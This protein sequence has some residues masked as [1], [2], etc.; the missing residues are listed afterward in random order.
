M[1]LEI[2]IIKDVSKPYWENPEVIRFGDISP[3]DWESL[4]FKDFEIKSYLEDAPE[5]RDQRAYRDYYSK[6]ISFLNERFPLIVRIKDYYEDALYSK[7]EI[8]ELI[9]EI[10]S[11]E[12]I[13]KS[14][15]SI[16]FLHQLLKACEM[17]VN[18]D[19]GIVLAAD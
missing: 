1:P 8:K 3:L 15:G 11:L 6:K 10:L 16:R 2:M 18:N 7:Y 17:A 13:A 12:D 19:A 4:F 14:Q 9:R 5:A